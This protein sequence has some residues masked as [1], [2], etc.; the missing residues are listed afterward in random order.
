MHWYVVNTASVDIDLGTQIL[1]AHCGTLDMPTREAI[2]PW[3]FPMHGMIR[4][5]THSLE[6]KCKV[7]GIFLCHIVYYLRS[8]R[9]FFLFQLLSA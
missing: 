6:P 5:T 3:A 7:I 9:A 8:H 4:E 2:P 1:H